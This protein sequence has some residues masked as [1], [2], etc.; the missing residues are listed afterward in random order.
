MPLVVAMRRGAGWFLTISI[1]SGIN[2]LLQVFDANLRFIF[3]LGT[4]QVIDALAHGRGNAA[5]IPMILVDGM[6]LGILLLCWHYAKAGS[7]GAF[8]V[9]MIAYALD[10]GLLLLFRVWLDAAVHAY[11]LFMIWR[12]YAAAREL[13]RTPQAAQPEASEPI[14]S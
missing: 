9:G 5:M 2:T 10:G 11:A 14:A 6:F 4:T 8:L 12:G 13:A 3:G 1:L 7:R